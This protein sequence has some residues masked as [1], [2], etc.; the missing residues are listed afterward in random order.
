MGGRKQK[1]SKVQKVPRAGNVFGKVFYLLDPATNV[2]ASTQWQWMFDNTVM[3]S[4]QPRE[5]TE[6]QRPLMEW[7]K[8]LN[9]WQR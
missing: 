9:D 1:K 3:Q 7:L 8:P 4:W 6:W 5:F 2:A